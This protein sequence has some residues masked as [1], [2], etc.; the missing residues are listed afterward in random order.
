MNPEYES[1]VTPA[2]SVP[3]YNTVI[4]L[5][6]TIGDKIRKLDFYRA[7]ANNGWIT[8]DTNILDREEFLN[9]KLE[10]LNNI[11]IMMHEILGVDKEIGFRLTNSWANKHIKG[12]WAHK[13]YHKNSFWSGVIYIET[14]P[15]GGHLQLQRPYPTVF[16]PTLELQSDPDSEDNLI[17]IDN[18]TIWPGRGKLILFPSYVNHWVTE[19]KTDIERITMAFNVWPTGTI[20]TD[21]L[22]TIKL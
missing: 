2:F 21:G 7:E 16:P 11:H 8:M 13:H 1:R 5:E 9:L 22:D 3:I 6:D 10:V 20:G 4:N 18:W 14:P 19:N 17:N 12:D 15:D